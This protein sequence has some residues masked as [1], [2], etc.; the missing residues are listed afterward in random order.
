MDKE[1]TPAALVV[2]ASLQAAGM[3]AHVRRKGTADAGARAGQ[4]AATGAQLS[5]SASALHA[6]T[7]LLLSA[8]RFSVA[9]K[10]TNCTALL[11][12]A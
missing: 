8:L 7:S 9:N 4:R 12:S 5:P 1:K 6:F 10:C 3:R 11:K 2:Y